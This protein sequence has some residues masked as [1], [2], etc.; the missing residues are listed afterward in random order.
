[1]ATGIRIPP[2]VPPPLRDDYS[3]TYEESRT[4]VDMDAGAPR[5]RNKMRTAPRLFT[6][7]WHMTAAVYKVFDIWFAETVA[8]GA[9]EFD[10]QLLDDSETL[11][12]YTATFEKGSYRAAVE[13]GGNWRVS[14]TLRAVGDSFPTR[15][16]GTDELR[17][18]A[19]LD[20]TAPR[21]LLVI[22]KVLFGSTTL[23]IG[24]GTRG[25]LKPVPLYGRAVLDLSGRGKLYP[26]PLYGRA[27]LSLT[28]TGAPQ[29]FGDP[30]VILQFDGTA[31]T[32]DNGG[33]VELQFDSTVYY[34]P[35]V[36]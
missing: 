6:V 13:D 27:T 30:E 25:V 12:W 16:P 26:R 7:S 8:G 24:E 35:K 5:T 11:V 36:L 23:G 32:E 10:I 14:A 4:A 2:Q 31:Y 1:M 33:T 19:A 34:P 18:V 22:Q 29:V 17:G 28:A 21:G 15:P 20:L 3:D 9:R